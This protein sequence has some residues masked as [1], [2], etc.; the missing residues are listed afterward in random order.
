MD[1]GAAS[2]FRWGDNDVC[3]NEPAE[4]RVG[5]RALG[6]AWAWPCRYDGHLEPAIRLD[7]FS[8]ALPDDDRRGPHRHPV[9]LFLAHRA[10][11]LFLAG[12]GLADRALWSARA[13]HD[14]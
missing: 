12:A 13:H 6:S 5:A 8:Q 1:E 2:R 3:K 10:A 11:D 14:R 9:H 7:G 4:G